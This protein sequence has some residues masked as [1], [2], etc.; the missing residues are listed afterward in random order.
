[1]K[2]LDRKLLI[3]PYLTLC[4]SEKEWGKILRHLKVKD[5][6]L[7]WLSPEADATMHELVHSQR[8]PV[9][10][11][12]MDPEMLKRPLVEGL[13]LLAHETMHVW[14]H[15]KRGLGATD[16]DGELEA[17]SFQCLFQTLAAEFLRRHKR[18]KRTK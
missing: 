3:G 11:L 12:C 6:R 5:V 15:I 7:P 1:M 4:T 13:G 14:Q 17:Y 10:I 18:A 16:P 8:D 9:I 2:W